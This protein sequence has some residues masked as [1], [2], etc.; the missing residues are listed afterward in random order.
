MSNAIIENGSQ[1]ATIKG[2]MKALSHTS[3]LIEDI[4]VLAKTIKKKNFVYCSRFIIYYWA[5]A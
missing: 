5:R 3:N 1:I 4:N 2:D